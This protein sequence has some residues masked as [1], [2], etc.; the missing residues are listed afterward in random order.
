MLAA[1]VWT[2][3]HYG[4]GRHNGWTSDLHPVRILSGCNLQTLA[5]VKWTNKEPGETSGKREIIWKMQEIF[6]SG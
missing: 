4:G 6:W 1:E 3:D 5:D 2:L